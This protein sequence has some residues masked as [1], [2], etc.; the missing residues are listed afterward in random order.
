MANLSRA[1]DDRDVVAVGA[2]HV[3]ACKPRYTGRFVWVV[4]GRKWGERVKRKISVFHVL[5]AGV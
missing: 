4:E 5:L 3:A 1:S 2:A